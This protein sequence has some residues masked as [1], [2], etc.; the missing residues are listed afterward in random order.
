MADTIKEFL[1]SLGWQ[2][3]D[4]QHIKFTAML[5]GATLRAKLL[6]DGLEEVARKVADRVK[7]VA[8]DFERLY[9]QSIR[10]GQSAASIKD[11]AYAVS[12]LGGTAEGA[13]GSLEAMGEKLRA[14]PGN[15]TYLNQ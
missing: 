5:E 13:V 9:Y 10:T 12:Q 1:V 6:G 3:N 11:F 4:A 7:A 14:N 2:S 8:E 15:I